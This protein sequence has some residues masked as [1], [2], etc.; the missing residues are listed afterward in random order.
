ML[1][2]RV[3]VRQRLG[4][5]FPYQGN[6]EGDE[7]AFQRKLARVL[8]GVQRFLGVLFPIAARFLRRAQVQ[9]GE[10]F[11]LQGEEVQRGGSQAGAFSK[12]PPRKSRC[13]PR[14][15]RSGSRSG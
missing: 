15:A 6:A 7:P 3:R 1:Q 5:Y 10:L 13:F 12:L 4:D 2:V 9:V 11:Q 14:P 8:Q